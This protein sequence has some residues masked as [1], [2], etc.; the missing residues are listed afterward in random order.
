MD[1]ALSRRMASRMKPW[2]ILAMAAGVAIATPS[3]ASAGPAGSCVHVTAADPGVAAELRRAFVA[4]LPLAAHACFDVSLVS[5]EVE[6]QG[7]EVVMVAHVR[8]AVSDR[9]HL[10]AIVE[11][12]ATLHTSM[13]DVRRRRALI[14]RDVLDEAVASLLPAL[15]S[16]L[17]AG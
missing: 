11:G 6:I 15:R 8:V 10:S 14:E 12:R 3:R 4:E 9:D 5:M 13:R 16:R 17:T 2:I 7:A 1:G